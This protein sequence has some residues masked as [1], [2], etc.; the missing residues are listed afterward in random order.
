MIE[1]LL[2]VLFV[3]GLS[4]IL[5]IWRFHP[6]DFERPQD[7]RQNQ[8]LNCYLTVTSQNIY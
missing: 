4:F 6:S 7:L 2:Y 8:D 1:L 3:E 5:A